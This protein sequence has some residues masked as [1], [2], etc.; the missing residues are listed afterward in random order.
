MFGDVTNNVIDWFTSV[1]LI[2]SESSILSLDLTCLPYP[3]II[4][5]FL[6]HNFEKKKKR[7]I[8]RLLSRKKQTRFW[9]SWHEICEVEG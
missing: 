5:G 3:Q 9:F 2:L 1:I 6:R 4:F 7:N 8:I